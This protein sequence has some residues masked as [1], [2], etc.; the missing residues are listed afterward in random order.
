MGTLWTFGCSYTAPYSTYPPWYKQYYEFRGGNFPDTWTQI[1]SKKLNLNLTNLGEMGSGFDSA[2][3][4]FC[5]SSSKI[6]PGDTVIFQV[7]QIERF[8]VPGPVGRWV[9]CSSETDE[10]FLPKN[11]A[12]YIAVKRYS[13]VQMKEIMNYINFIDHFSKVSKFRLFFWFTPGLLYE[14]VDLNDRKFLLNNHI[15]PTEGLD[16]FTTVFNSVFELGGERIYEETKGEIK[17]LHFGESGHRIMAD[18][19][20]NH[21]LECT[22]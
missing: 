1:L 9:N 5:I 20:Y 19:F 4:R 6:K 3:E 14:F 18:L 11:I 8:R 12:E 21:I 7:P 15:K 10:E 22:I 16:K 17:D 2:F 13:Y